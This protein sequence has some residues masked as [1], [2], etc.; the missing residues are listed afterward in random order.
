L[1]YAQANQQG[2]GKAWMKHLQNDWIIN[3]FLLI[4]EDTSDVCAQASAQPGSV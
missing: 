1:K 3:G 2:R 4:L